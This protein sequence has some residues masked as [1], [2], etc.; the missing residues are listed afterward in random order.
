MD[1]DKGRLQDPMVSHL[2]DHNMDIHLQEDLHP[3]EIGVAHPQGRLAGSRV[4]IQVKV[5]D[6]AEDKIRTDSNHTDSRVM[7]NNRT[8]KSLMDKG[9]MDKAHP[10]SP[11]M[12]VTRRAINRVLGRGLNCLEWSQ[13]DLVIGG[14]HG[15]Q[16]IPKIR[17]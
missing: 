9:L 8:G 7:V 5:T 17:R 6:P 15:R 4:G 2:Q 16:M 3:R 10:G 11:G 14:S 1:T 12:T 13:K